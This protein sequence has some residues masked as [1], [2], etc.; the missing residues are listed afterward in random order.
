MK[1]DSDPFTVNVIE[2]ANKKMLIQSHQTE[3]AEGKNVVVHDSVPP[4]MI[5][6]KN[7]EVGVWKVNKGKKPVLK[8]RP[9]PTFK[10]LLEKYTS[11]K[12]TNVFS[13]LGGAKRPRSPPGH[14]Y[15]DQGY[16][17]GE[18]YV[19]QPYFAMGP[20]HWSYPP[21]VYPLF[22]SWGCDPWAPYPAVLVT[23]FQQRWNAPVPIGGECLYNQR[24]RE[25]RTSD[26]IVIHGGDH[27]LPKR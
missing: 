13:R 23:H 15:G 7:P 8:P 27:N 3:S 22:P 16:W 4:R 1:L 2:F 5:K 26:A 6:P 24:G 12:N 19:Q 18:S 14:N 20:M 17:H 11:Q 25:A 21:P 10:Q 9:R